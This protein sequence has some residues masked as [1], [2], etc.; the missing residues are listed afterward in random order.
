[1]VICGK[2]AKVLFPAILADTIKEQMSEKFLI[3]LFQAG[4]HIMII[5]FY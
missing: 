4:P 2:E 1:M 5:V 3:S